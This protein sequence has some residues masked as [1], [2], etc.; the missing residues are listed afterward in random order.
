MNRKQ[1][2]PTSRRQRLVAVIAAIVVTVTLFEGVAS[3]APTTTRNAPV[4]AKKGQ[5][6]QVAQASEVQ[7]RR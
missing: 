2:T 6:T 7:A 3:I 1:F 5:P 4:L